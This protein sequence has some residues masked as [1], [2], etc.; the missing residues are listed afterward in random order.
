MPQ[1]QIKPFAIA[2]GANVSSQDEW[3]NS[4]SLREG[5]SKGL[6]RSNEVNKAIR[7]TSS[8]AA[9]VAQ[10]TASQTGEDILDNGDIGQLARQ[11][12]MAVNAVSASY[13]TRA[14]G[15]ANELIASFRP[16]LKNLKDGQTVLVRA[17][18][19][20][21]SKTVTLKIEN[22]ETR[23]IVKGNNLSLEEGDIAGTGHW[24]ELQYDE[25]LDKWVLQNP[26]KGI[27]P[28]SGVPIGTIEYFAASE[29]PAGYL[30]AD[31]SEIGRETYPDLFR[32]IGITYGRGDG[33]MTFNLPDLID[34]FA[35]GSKTPGHKVE[36]G[37]PNLEGST[38]GFRSDSDLNPTGVFKVGSISGISIGIPGTYAG[39]TA[40]LDASLSNPIYGASNTVQPPALALLPCIK[41]FDA[42]TNSG[43]IEISGLAYEVGGKID[44]IIAGKST[45]YIIDR[46]KDIAGNWWRKWSDGWLEQGGMEE[47]DNTAD[48]LKTINFL[49]PFADSDYFLSRTYTSNF[50]NAIQ[51][52]K[53]WVG[54]HEQLPTQFSYYY[55]GRYQ[56][57]LWY[58]CGQGI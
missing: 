45:A 5:F 18:E 28:A 34:R 48:L 38:G 11:I 3:E 6:A 21:T 2:E 56:K 58:A 7:Q 23:A 52:A 16:A 29:P 46:Y 17:K 42:A 39:M 49:I 19:K 10:F 1:I 35:Q 22:K 40:E 50:S 25:S 57:T 47:K 51:T 54:H 4:I 33:E 30:K 8:V 14:G 24:L 41:A 32:I 15:E 20:N 53:L 43:L 9:A 12:E 13:T 26:A 55:D 37:L 27:N 44:K 31:G 36:A